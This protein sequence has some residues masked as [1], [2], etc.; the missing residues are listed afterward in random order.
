MKEI[1]MSSKT[2]TKFGAAFALVGALG[3][4][5]LGGVAMTKT[6]DTPPPEETTQS[7]AFAGLHTTAPQQGTVADGIRAGFNQV[8]IANGIHDGLTQVEIANGIRDGLTQGAIANGI[9]DGLTQAAIANGIRAG[10]NQ[11][12]SLNPGHVPTIAQQNLT[13]RI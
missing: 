12:N 3:T 8:A 9:H 4:A 7:Q 6:D 2:F 13:L 10:L 11:G 5:L 1:E